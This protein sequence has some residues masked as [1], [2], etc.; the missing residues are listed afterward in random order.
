MGDIRGHT[1]GDGVFGGAFC[2]S[3]IRCD[4]AGKGRSDV[5]DFDIRVSHDY[6]SGP[7][8]HFR[9][10]AFRKYTDSR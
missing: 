2:K 5:D 1:L 10:I 6:G 4:V 7:S 3:D 9:A 8:F